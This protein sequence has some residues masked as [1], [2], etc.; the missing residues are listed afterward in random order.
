[1]SWKMEEGPIT[2]SDKPLLNDAV[3]FSW[4]ESVAKFVT[5]SQNSCDQ[6]RKMAG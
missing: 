1:M 6:M 3:T 2:L 4:I 5:K